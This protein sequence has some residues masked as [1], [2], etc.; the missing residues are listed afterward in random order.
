V[1]EYIERPLLIKGYKFDIRLWVLLHVTKKAE[2]K[3]SIDIYMFKEGYARL[4]SV[5]Y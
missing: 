4:A 3:K 5:K 2:N 1:Q